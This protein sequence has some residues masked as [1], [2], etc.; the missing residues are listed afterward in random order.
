MKCLKSVKASIYTPL[1]FGRPSL[2]L[3]RL[4]A[5]EDVAPTNQ[6][7]PIEGLRPTELGPIIQCELIEASFDVDLVPDYEA[8]SYTWGSADLSREIYLDGSYLL[9]T[10]NLWSLLHDLRYQSEDRI[11]WIDAICIDQG[12]HGERGHQVQQMDQ[13]YHR[14]QRVIFWLGVLTDSISILMDILANLQ[15]QMPGLDWPPNDHRWQLKWK[16][17]RKASW[18]HQTTFQSAL[19]EI[20]NRP[21]FCRVWI[22]QEVANARAAVVHCGPK[23]VS[24]RIFAVCPFLL[25][26]RIDIHCQPVF[27]VMPGPSRRDS[28]WSRERDLL[29]LLEKFGATQATREHDMIFALLG[30]CPE[31]N[32]KIS[33]DY[34]MSIPDLVWET[35]SFI[36]DYDMR[37]VPTVRYNTV[38]HFLEDIGQI[39]HLVLEHMLNF[40]SPDISKAFLAKH[41]T[42]LTLTMKLFQATL[43]NRGLSEESLVEIYRLRISQPAAVKIM[44][45]TAQASKNETASRL[46]FVHYPMM[47]KRDFTKPTGYFTELIKQHHSNIEATKSY[48][49]EG[50]TPLSRASWLGQETAVSMLLDTGA[51]P[52]FEDARGDTPL[53]VAS[54]RG[55]ETVARLLLERGADHRRKDSSGSTPL[56]LASTKGH[57]S[58]VRLLLDQGAGPDAQDNSDATP[59]SRAS[60]LGHVAVV[61]LL[62]DRGASCNTRD[63]P[64]G[65]TPM[66]LASEEGNADVVRLLLENGANLNQRN[67]KTETPLFV[68]S[69]A[70]RRAVVQLLLDHG[71]D[72]NTKHYSWGKPLFS[73]AMDGGNRDIVQL[74]IDNG[75]QPPPLRSRVYRGGQNELRTAAQEDSRQE[76]PCRILV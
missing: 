33:V 7:P 12:N 31:A 24:A 50:Y 8:V 41:K 65:N 73:A 58:L 29:T 62:L 71:A 76:Q 72:C 60:G 38:R 74:L 10:F 35:I 3:L 55:N 70:A 34:N 22:L 54:R 63:K 69:R 43:S 18:V 42:K 15:E 64:R 2:R 23:S 6:P 19:R 5:F 11:L 26:Y 17:V 56:M 68:A 14:A 9:V 40:A 25:N 57:E 27:D 48:D 30:L 53:I 16:Q 44:Q 1:D 75:A 45:E 59:L 46:F 47:F 20:L 51:L 32:A 66:I 28:W 49:I 39:R 61:R 4:R 36:F 37:N 52:D 21:W 67:K 13:I